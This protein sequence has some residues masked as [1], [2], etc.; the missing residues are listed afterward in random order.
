LANVPPA[1]AD[2]G[3]AKSS[4]AKSSATRS[5]PAGSG[6]VESGAAKPG[7]VNGAASLSEQQRN[8]VN[9]VGARLRRRRE[10]AGL[11]LRAFART[12]GVSA[13]FLSQ[14]ENGKSRPS[15]A[16]LYL[17]CNALDLSIDELFS[18]EEPAAA[19]AAPVDRR[20]SAAR[21]EAEAG[22]ARP[23]S[24]RAEAPPASGRDLRVGPEGRRGPHS[25]LVRPD[26]RPVLVLDSGVT[27]ES[28]TSMHE[29]A[30]DFMFVRYEVGGSSTLD[31]RFIR[32]MGTEYGYIISG[33]LEITLGFEKYYLGPGDAI[34]FD[35]STPHRLTTVGDEPVEAV[36]FVHGRTATHDH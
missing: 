25:P 36:W 16:T 23:G 20:Q 9:N 32:H 14:L 12:L 24:A 28:L 3:P 29:A 18:P 27:W 31:G 34:S 30:V 13:S 17:I 6:P 22:P 15:V 19:G 1:A 4:P 35:S 10:E 21:A 8:A 2:T 33:T 11:S 7:A 26:E 5:S